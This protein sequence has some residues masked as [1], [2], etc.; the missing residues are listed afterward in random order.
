M[1]NPFLVLGGIAVGVVTAGFGVLQVPG[2]V[3]SAQDAAAINDLSH[4]RDSQSVQLAAHSNYTPDVNAL[5]G[6]A[7]GGPGTSFSLDGATLTHFGVSDDGDAYCA[8]IR[9]DSGLYFSTSEKEIT[10]DGASTAAT[11]MDDAGCEPETRTR[12]YSADQIVFRV[13]TEAAGCIAPGIHL[14]N[15]AGT[16]E[17]ADG[18][19]IDSGT[20]AAAQHTYGEPGVY[21]IIVTGTFEDTALMPA[22]A[23]PCL[24]E[25]P[26]FGAKTGVKHLDHAFD[27]AT[28]LTAVATPPRGITSMARTFADATSFNQSIEH[29]DVSKVTNMSALFSGATSFNQPLDAWKTGEL[30][31]AGGLFL[32]ATSFD[33]PLGGWDTSNVRDFSNAFNGAS[34]FNQPL[35]RWDVSSAQA[36]SWMFS[37]ASSFSQDLSGWTND[38]FAADPSKVDIPSFIQSSGLTPAQ[39]PSWMH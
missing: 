13:N 19:T 8:T 31:Y 20:L 38:T 10:T 37:S 27:G 9:S 11:A 3:S 36:M 16:I 39:L 14:T 28:N 29:W 2:W 23:A 24:I 7:T 26:H 25:V 34:A 4:I 15:G 35:G 21:D 32:G 1:A 6:D 18:E 12:A 17:W 5:T 30:R 33:Q 22:G